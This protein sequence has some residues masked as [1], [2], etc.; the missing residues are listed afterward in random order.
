[1]RAWDMGPGARGRTGGGNT[2]VEMGVQ[3]PWS[4]SMGVGMCGHVWAYE[5]MGS[6][7]GQWARALARKAAA[8][9]PRKESAQTSTPAPKSIAPARLVL[10]VCFVSLFR[11]FFWGVCL[12]WGAGCLGGLF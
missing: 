1:M 5:D 7:R 9:R 11:E 2:G 12:G 4:V 10:G 8:T 3:R 6:V